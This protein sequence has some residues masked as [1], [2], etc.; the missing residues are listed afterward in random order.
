MTLNVRNVAAA[1]CLYFECNEI[2]TT[3]CFLTKGFSLRK[4]HID[5]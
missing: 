3:I 1:W 5:Y 2:H 4:E